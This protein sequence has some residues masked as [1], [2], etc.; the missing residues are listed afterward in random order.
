MATRNFTAALLVTAIVAAACSG[1]G[2]NAAT[3]TALAE[4]VTSTAAP[5]TTTTTTTT[6]PATTQP[7]FLAR[8]APLPAETIAGFGDPYDP[9]LGNGGFDVQHYTLDLSF[10]PDAD[11]L[12]GTVTIEAAAIERLE[13]FHLDFSG[14][15][16]SEILVDA[17]EAAFSREG[18]ELVVEAPAP[19]PAGEGFSVAVTYSGIPEPR[20]SPAIELVIGWLTDPDGDRYVIAEPD[21]ASTWFPCNDHPLDKAT[22]IFRLTV[23]D[24]LLAA[25]NGELV[26]T[27]T[28]LG[29][30]TWVWEMDQPMATY[31]ATVVIGD[32]EVV[33][34]EA[35]SRLSGTTI[36][37]VL[38]KEFLA[39]PPDGIDLHGEM[40]A[41]FDDL[42]GP[43]PFD[44]YGI[45]LV[46][47]LPGALENQTLSVFGTD[48]L[49]GDPVPI[50][51][52]ASL[53][54]FE[55]VM[56]HELAH[57]WFG[58]SVSPGA[59]GDIW[60]NEGFASYAEFLWIEHRFDR[61]LME[62]GIE[63]ERA[64]WAIS[65]FDP[66][67]NPPYDN[68][69][70]GA[71]YRLGAMTLHALRLTVGDGD[72]FEILQTYHRTFAGGTA[73]TGDFIAVAEEL[74]GLD[75]DDLFDAWLYSG[76]VPEFPAANEA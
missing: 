73:T 9:D 30:A 2:D 18:R 66:P 41:F 6:A 3:T 13:T 31:L 51:P 69:F 64:F 63:G 62:A 25:A 54:L 24:P 61:E 47:N 27:I 12:A 40:L 57:Q 46:D 42:F 37:H 49:Y 19:I 7:P 1:S 45:T 28:D 33:A 67:G 35:G 38:P 16:I 34:D 32:Y 60:L 39:D 65:A 11:V 5:T 50:G 29:V 75:L 52:T 72:F 4:G 22:Y 55:L 58:D 76:E 26:D 17:E 8:S 23:P 44:E 68:L 21:G 48:V 43:F 56:V 70:N 36:R 14:F 53:P 59:W 20:L 71:V 15:E 10:D 74:S